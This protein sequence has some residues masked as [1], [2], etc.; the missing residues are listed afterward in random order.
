MRRLDEPSKRELLNHLHSHDMRV[1]IP[2]YQKALAIISSMKRNWTPEELILALTLYYNI[3]F[4][5]I[6]YSHP[7]I[8]SLSKIIIIALRHAVALKLVNFSTPWVR[9]AKKRKAS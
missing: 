1:G 5:K 4:S 7:E 9:I 3:P 8:K 6:H 2:R